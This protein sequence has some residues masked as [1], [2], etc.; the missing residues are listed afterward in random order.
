[1][2]DFI[3]EVYVE[4][5]DSVHLLMSHRQRSEDGWGTVKE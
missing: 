2:L 3:E 4:V 1:M 5:L